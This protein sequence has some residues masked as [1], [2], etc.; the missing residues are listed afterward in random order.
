MINLSNISIRLKMFIMIVSPI[1]GVLF[2]STMGILDRVQIV[3]EMELLEG[4]SKLAVKF[5]T[6][7]HELQKEG[8]DT[9][10]SINAI[11]VAID[12]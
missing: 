12:F 5:C 3:N 8:G 9:A 2:F 10:L 6:L 7:V 11:T 1:A 4:I